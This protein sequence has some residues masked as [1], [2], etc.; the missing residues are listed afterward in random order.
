MRRG[1]C[2][3]A[4]IRLGSGP[5]STVTLRYQEY[6]GRVLLS[7][8]DTRSWL[9]KKLIL[10][11]ITKGKI[12][13]LVLIVASSGLVLST[14]AF[15]AVTAERTASVAVQG[16]GSAHLQLTAYSG[17]GGNGQYAEIT[18]GTIQIG[19]INVNASTTIEK[20]FNITNQGSQP[21]DVWIDDKDPTDSDVLGA[22]DDDNTGAITFYN[23]TLGGSAS[24]ENG[25]NSVEGQGNAVTLDTGETMVVSI[26]IDTS[27]IAQDE[28]DLL[29][30][31]TIHAEAP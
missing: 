5:R 20:V 9:L 19:S 10:I 22:T 7:I 17:P 28:I 24:T 6:A 29:D 8:V 31:I 1:Q 21:V 27:G 15:S 25:V 11:M 4:V 12:F 3:S 2:V 13:A 18:D 23:P 14:G 26:E 16:D 30:E